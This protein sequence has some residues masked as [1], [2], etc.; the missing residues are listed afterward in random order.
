MSDVDNK[1]GLDLETLSGRLAYAVKS[2]G[3]SYIAKNT[4]LG[5][6]QVSR[7]GRQLGGTTLEK[8][9]EIAI[10]TGFE[11]KWIA[12]GTGPM[13]VNDEL[14]EHTNTF[15]KVPQ[16]DESQSADFSFDPEFLTQQKVTAQQCYIWQVDCHAELTNLRRGYTVLIDTQ[17]TQGSGVFVLESNTQRLIGEM[18]IN[19]DGSAKFRTDISKPNTDQD[20]TKEQLKEL[21][22]IG[23]VIWYG[24]QS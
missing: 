17:L 18:H 3:P 20:L 16:L 10:A 2:K 24:A 15:E 4:T 6:A 11:L 9:A 14:W 8:A 22:I 5:L 19:L 13:M 1:E 7:L 21:N 12:L 23:K